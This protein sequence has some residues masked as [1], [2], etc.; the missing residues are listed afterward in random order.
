[1]RLDVFLVEKKFAASRT[2]AQE[3]I[4]AGHVYLKNEAQNIKLVKSSYQVTDH[5]SDL[6]FVQHNEIQKYVSRGGLK[7][8]QAIKTLSLNLN[9]Q[10]ALDVGQSTGGF[11][12]CLLSHKV[13]YIV[14]IDVGHDQ[15][16][17]KIKSNEL[18]KSFEG[19]HIKD[20]SKNAEYLKAIPAGGFDILVA[21]VSFISLI[22]VMCHIKDFLKVG[23]SYL[24]LVKPQFELTATDLDKNGIVKNVKSYELVQQKIILEAQQQFGDVLN[25]FNS[26]KLGKDGNQEFFIYG[27]KAI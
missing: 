18:V 2:Q 14:G 15:L 17:E 19:L 23:G 26:E 22:K 27:K 8:E 1:M 24:F 4:V 3:L 21:D 5:D 25:Y 11:T 16:H 9:N 10:T 12:D 13:K 20:L 6:I 7:L